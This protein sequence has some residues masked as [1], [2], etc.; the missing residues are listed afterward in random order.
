MS[1][2]KN[3]FNDVIVPEIS[4][5]ASVDTEFTEHRFPS[6]L[7]TPGPLP[8]LESSGAGL[9]RAVLQLAALVCV[10]EHKACQ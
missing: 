10:Q 5:N 1:F 3:T 9:T 2:W 4:L 7:L 8:P 6:F